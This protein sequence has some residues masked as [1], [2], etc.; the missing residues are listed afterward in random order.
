M[1]PSALY[2]QLVSAIIPGVVYAD[3]LPHSPCKANTEA[4]RQRRA[5][6]RCM[7]RRAERKMKY[8]EVK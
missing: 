5:R 6:T 2:E 8:L 1:P 7:N 3:L 4:K